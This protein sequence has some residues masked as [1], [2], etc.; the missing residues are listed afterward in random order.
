MDH[1]RILNAYLS[2][3][4]TADLENIVKHDRLCLAQML[5]GNNNAQLDAQA[6][7]YA[8]ICQAIANFNKHDLELIENAILEVTA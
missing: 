7:F 6:G 2:R 5:N 1:N 3:L 8:A 4:T